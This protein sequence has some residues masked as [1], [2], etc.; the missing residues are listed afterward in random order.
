MVQ[1]PQLIGYVSGV[2]LLIVV[3]N[4]IQLKEANLLG[5]LGDAVPDPLFFTTHS[6]LSECGFIAD[7]QLELQLTLEC[8]GLLVDCNKL[9]WKPHLLGLI[10]ELVKKALNLPE[11]I[12]CFL[13]YWI[14]VAV[15]QSH[16]L[17]EM[18]SSVKT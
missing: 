9:P 3:I 4:Y 15:S 16:K 10:I 7:S 2:H 11:R 6:T 18:L 12:L 14:L 5:V 17:M 13:E 8:N 1:S